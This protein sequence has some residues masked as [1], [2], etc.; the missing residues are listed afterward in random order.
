MDS[1]NVLVVEVPPHCTDQLQPLVLGV[2][3]AIEGCLKSKFQLW[4]AM[5]VSQQ[6]KEKSVVEPADLRLPAMKPLGANRK[7]TKILLQ[8]CWS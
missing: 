5:N 6:L 2:N 1:N 3:K 7:V 8:I 4:Y